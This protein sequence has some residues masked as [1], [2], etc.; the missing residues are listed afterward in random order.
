M[1]PSG[2]VP[3]ESVCKREAKL[4]TYLDKRSVCHIQVDQSHILLLPGCSS[5][6]LFGKINHTSL[7]CGNLGCAAVFN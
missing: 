4:G 2:R 1:Y 3:I 7:T 5:S 6:R